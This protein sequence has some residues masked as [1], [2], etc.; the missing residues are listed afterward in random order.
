MP[1]DLRFNLQLPSSPNPAIEDKVYDEFR[2]V[3]NALRALAFQI[4]GGNM[5]A[6][7]D[8]TSESQISG[9]VSGTILLKYLTQDVALVQYDLI[10]ESL[11]TTLSFTLPVPAKQDQSGSVGLALDNSA[12]IT[13]AIY[14][15]EVGSN[16]VQFFTDAAHTG[17]TASGTKSIEG[18]FLLYLGD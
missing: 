6:I 11:S 10:G 13:T 17:W 18:Q 2:T 5:A 14:V 16:V 9:D 7:A 15:L 8:I 12:Q 4:G 1:E 3:Y